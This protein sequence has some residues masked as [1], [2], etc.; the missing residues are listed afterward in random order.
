MGVA[1][2]SA[3]L[4]LPTEHFWL[5]IIS[6]EHGL[7]PNLRNTMSHNR[8]S[9][10]RWLRRPHLLSASLIA[11]TLLGTQGPAQAQVD[12]NINKSVWKQKYNVLDA[13]LNEQAPYAGW[14]SKDDDGDGVLNGDELAAGTNPFFKGAAEVHFKLTTLAANPTQMLLTFSTV[15]GK[16]YQ[17]ES[18]FTLT[19]AAW[20]A[21]FLP[22]VVGDGTPMTLTVPKSAGAFFHVKVSDQASQGDGVSDWAKQI[23]GFG[24]GSPITAQSGYT[25]GTLS[26]ALTTQQNVVTIAATHPNTT[27]PADGATA[28]TDLGVITV[29]RGGYYLFS[30]I[31]V[32]LS[33]LTVTGKTAQPGVDYLA[34]PNTVNFP[35]GVKSVELKVTPLYNAGLKTTRSVI[36]SVGSGGGYSIGAPSQ[37]VVTIYP[38][39]TPTGTGLTGLY[40]SGSNTTYTSSANFNTTTAS[41]FSRVDPTV[42]FLFPSGPGVPANTGGTASNAVAPVGAIATT[43]TSPYTVRWKGQVQPQYSQTYYF[44]ARSDDGAKLFVNGQL[45]IDKWQGQSVSDQVGAISLQAGVL[46]DIQMDY[47]QISGGAEAHLSWYSS[48]QV[49]QIIPQSRLYPAVTGVA[50]ATP[51]AITSAA[52]VVGFA[53]HL[54]STTAA[55]PPLLTVTASNGPSTF[56]LT[57]GSAPLPGS[58]TLNPATGAITG[59]ATVAGSYSVAVQA[60]NAAG[61]GSA[62]LNIQISDSTGTITRETWT[63]LAGRNVSDIPLTAAPSTT[64]TTL[65]SLEDNSTQTGGGTSTGERLRGYITVP[66]TGNYY[67][68]LAANGDAAATGNVA[69]LWVSINSDAVNKV[70][71]CFTSGPNGTASHD[72]LA[73]ASQRSGWLS[74][75]A[76]QKYYFELL[77][78]LGAAAP[79]AGNLAVGW[80]MDPTGST[81]VNAGNVATLVSVTPG[82]VLSA[83]DNPATTAVSGALYVTDLSAIPGVSSPATGSAYLRLTGPAA[84]VHYANPTGLSSAVTSKGIYTGTLAAPTLVFDLDA[85]DKFYPGARTNDAG[86]T[87]SGIS[88]GTLTSLT[89]GTAF[90]LVKTVTNPNGEVSGRFGLT[91]GS[92]VAPA[93]ATYPAWTDSHSTSDADNSRFLTQATFG[94]SPAD[95]TSV[96]AAGYNA[97]INTQFGLAA[98]H[99]TPYV[100]AN[101][102]SDPTNGY[103]SDRAFNSWWQQSV[104][105]PDQ[106]R[107]RLAFALSEIMVVSDTGPLNNE[108]RYLSPYYDT[109]LDNCLGNFRSLLKTVSL[110]PSMGVYLDMRANDKG[111]FTTGLHPNENYA[112]E[113]MQLFS[114][115]LYR[116]W[117][118]ATL[119]LD[120]AGSPV[121]TY[122]QNVIT[123]FARVLTGWNWGQNLQGNNRLPTNFFPAQ[124]FFAPMTLVPPH[125]ELGSKIGLDNVMLPAANAAV[126]PASIA[127]TP[128]T[129]PATGTQADS[130]NSGALPP[131]NLFDN[132]CTQDFEAMLDQIMNSSTVAPFICR[133]LI[134]R[135]V[136]SSPQP[137]YVQRVVRAFN[138]EQFVDAQGQPIAGSGVRGNMQEVVRAILLDY[139]ARSTAARNALTFGK[140][141]EPL[142][143]I[144]GPARS[145]P[146]A[147]IP[148]STYRELGGQPILITT[149]TAHRLASGDTVT[150]D[151][152]ADAGAS[153]TNL[154]TAQGYSVANATPGYSLVAPTSPYSNLGS[155]VTI[156]ASGYVAGNPIKVKFSTGGLSTGGL[157]DNTYTIATATAASFTITLPSSPANASGNCYFPNTTVTV[158]SP[159]YQAGDTVN[160]QFTS[161]T[162]GSNAPY[163]TVQAYTVTGVTPTNFTVSIASNNFAATSGNTVTP[164]NF[165]VNAGS[166]ATLNYG[167]TGSA[168]TLTAGGYTAGQQLYV[169]FSSGG[170]LNAGFNGLYSV[171]SATA[172]DFTITLASTPANTSGNCLVPRLTGGYTVTT[173]STTSTITVATSGNHNLNTGDQVQLDF[174]AFNSPTPAVDGIYTVVSIVDS[175]HFTVTT[176]PAISNGSLGGA[177]NVYPLAAPPYSRNG[178][179][180]IQLST[181]SIGYSS[182]TSDLSQTPLN[183]PSVF[184][185]FYPDYQFPGS[186]AANGLSTPEFQ[187]SNDTGT[188][189]LTNAVSRSLLTSTTPNGYTSFRAGSGAIGMDLF[190]YMTPAQTSDAA[191]PALVDKM[192]DFLLGGSMQTNTRTQIISFV[193]NT[194]NFPFTTAAP[195]N[196]QMSNRVRAIVHMIIVSPEYAI[197][198]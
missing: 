141:R 68:Y 180:A 53:S 76:G 46:Y 93:A 15:G 122:D 84:V 19:D 65:T 115:G 164:N 147:T 155:T 24:T 183:A 117:P 113:I 81:T 57:P 154:P 158:T 51:P 6:R 192:N 144:T 18:K 134:Q 62:G 104:T 160:L 169:V 152:F 52:S 187:L 189:G 170:L 137:A 110:T 105:A 109:L 4:P 63:G 29:S 174:T 107:Q 86:Y 157:F 44:I 66:A 173:V 118:D 30:T 132:Y 59:T 79:A 67:F 188:M 175:D 34:L 64:D 26:S 167:S 116:L 25:S 54:Y 40:A 128:I 171:T 47:L 38:S 49:K 125:H 149:P 127:Y 191:I 145:F 23:L 48:D 71:R 92:Q 161:G 82:F 139:E 61:T 163:N 121:P 119:V 196:A 39:P 7:V 95:M 133:Q 35:V 91:N 146:A 108:S 13:Q 102:N 129:T 88:G 73:L 69:E 56:A 138:G 60:T 194:A 165:T 58:L 193:A 94:P 85:Q 123:G 106:L 103:P 178:T 41:G 186:I 182:D 14:L 11:L 153:S 135:L 32:P 162:L 190:P 5:Q 143:R 8:L 179:L 78:N 90:L 101:L 89:G 198:K 27:A 150:L 83:W 126:A 156:S 22:S 31:T 55:A 131:N 124:N 75:A 33:V 197:Q 28:A 12:A 114:L 77:H 3:K 185:F 111:D 72:Y 45:I 130:S 166:L 74:L 96:K 80:F 50:G 21:G 172:N 100:L 136:T 195:T 99:H 87:W 112:R 140:Q 43:A 151:T 9:T 16:L 98:S 159:G 20:L 142:L 10:P 1:G 148:N 168:V 176:T 97:W 17:A 184:N 36:V 120:S 42:D 177:I 70:R 2:Y 37:A 181:W